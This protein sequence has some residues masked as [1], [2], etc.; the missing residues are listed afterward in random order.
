MK[1]SDAS[2]MPLCGPA[3]MRVGC[4]AALDQG[5]AMSKDQ[6][7]QFE[8]QHICKTIYYLI[9]SDRL[10][11]DSKLPPLDCG[12]DEMAVHLVGMIESGELRI[13]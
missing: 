3:Y 13:A 12:L 5:K 9:D 6:R 2:A 7:K 8:D 4:H 10:I 1:A 11:S